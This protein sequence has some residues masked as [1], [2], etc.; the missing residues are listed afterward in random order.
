LEEAEAM[1]AFLVT[2]DDHPA[3]FAETVE[4][5]AAK[6]VN[7]V[8]ATVGDCGGGG[9]AAIMTNDESTTRVALLERGSPFQESEVIEV[10]LR[11]EPGSLARVC[12]R[13][14]DAGIDIQ[15]LLPVG[16]EGAEMEFGFV[17]DDPVRARELLEPAGMVFG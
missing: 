12:R 2:L 8:S 17:T 14:V 11:H 10:A 6:G 1:R 15:A 4:L 16:M 5:I 7:I 9:R 13:L 3:A